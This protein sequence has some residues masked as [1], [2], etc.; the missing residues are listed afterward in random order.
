MKLPP[1]RTE[2]VIDYAHFDHTGLSDQALKE[3]ILGKIQTELRALER[4]GYN[5]SSRNEG[6]W[7]CTRCTSLI[8]VAECDEGV[9]KLGDSRR[10]RAR[11]MVSEPTDRARA[12]VQHKMIATPAS[13]LVLI[14]ERPR[15]LHG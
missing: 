8:E 4:R 13:R 5:L 9:A 11:V 14:G 10:E 15:E 1:A 7:Y 6:V 12:C 3:Q 2:V